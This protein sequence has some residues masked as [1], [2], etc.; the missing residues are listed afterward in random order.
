MVLLTT[1]QPGVRR[2]SL[3][4][5]ANAGCVQTLQR[6]TDTLVLLGTCSGGDVLILGEATHGHDHDRVLVYGEV[7][8]QVTGDV[9]GALNLSDGA[10]PHLGVLGRKVH[11]EVTCEQV[12]Q[13]GGEAH[14]Q[15]GVKDVVDV[16][17]EVLV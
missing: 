10:F 4:R 17:L 2:Q 11:Q 7:A 6:L 8:G 3:S 16:N 15:L 9:D 12:G 5:Q 13:V 14:V 1:H